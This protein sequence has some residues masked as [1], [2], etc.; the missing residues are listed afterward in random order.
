[1]DALLAE[2]QLQAGEL[3]MG[4]STVFVGGGTPTVLPDDQLS[5]LVES[6]GKHVDESS[7]VEFTVEANPATLTESNATILRQF[8]ANR[9]S[10]GAQSFHPADLTVLERIHNPEDIAPGVRIARHA[11]FEQVNL[12]LIFA[13]PGQTMARWLE[14]L[15][16][17][18]SLEPEHLA[19]YALTFEPNTVLT[20]K[21]QHGRIAPC[22]ENLEA[23][24]LLAAHDL[25]TGQGFEHYEVSNY[26]LPGCRC[27]HNVNYWRNEPY[28]GIGPSGVSYLNGVRRKNVSDWT[29]YT[30][31]IRE[32][33]SAVDESETLSNYHRAGETAWL[34]LRLMAGIDVERFRIQTGL[35]PKDLFAKS[36]VRH[37]TGGHLVV[38]DESIRV[39]P[40]GLLLTDLIAADFL[41]EAIEQDPAGVRRRTNLPILE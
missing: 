22:D 7:S 21:M 20:A 9:L 14:S 5:R 19:C 10:M 33:G 18:L 6:V 31:M 8:G 26:A 1:M 2:L 25:L 41:N 39:S 4:A 34:A 24:M 13:I 17:A 16:K 11:G 35:A 30:A 28:L 36:I 32:E 27:A 3:P 15:E 37:G 23:D 40:T 12:D 38:T 29:R